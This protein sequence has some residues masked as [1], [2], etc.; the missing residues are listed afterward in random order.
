M[1]GEYVSVESRLVEERFFWVFRRELFCLQYDRN[2]FA[3]YC[4]GKIIFLSTVY[5]D[6]LKNKRE[7]FKKIPRV[8]WIA[9]RRFLEECVEKEIKFTDKLAYLRAYLKACGE[10]RED[11]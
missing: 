2:I 1:V 7:A 5:L 3:C 10:W 4:S 11:V 6:T 8:R 9:G